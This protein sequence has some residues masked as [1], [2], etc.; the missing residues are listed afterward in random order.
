MNKFSFKLIKK[1]QSARLGQII[2]PHGKIDT[3]IFM[4]VG[5]LGSVKTASPEEVVALGGQII[6][7]NNYHLYLRPGIDIIEKAGGIHS[8][9]G[10]K[11]PLLTDSGGFQVFS[12]GKGNKNDNNLVKVHSDGVEFRSHLDGSKHLF[13]PENVVEMQERIGADIIMC[14]DECAPHDSNHAYAFDAM[15]RTHEW[16]ER[17]LVAHEKAKRQSK[18]GNYQAIFGIV[19]GVLFDDL[20]IDSTKFMAEHNFDGIAIGGLSVG[21]SKAEM[22]HIL[23]IIAPFLPESKPRYLMGVGSPEDLLEGVERGIDM[24]DCVLAT[25]IARNGSVWTREGRINLNNAVFSADFQPID[26]ECDCYTCQN[27]SRAYIAHLI[28]E[29]EIFGIRLTT[30]HNLRFLMNLM[31]EVRDS[32]SKNTFA[33]YKKE[34]LQQFIK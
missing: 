12:L 18:Q 11:G 8:F 32:I 4:P 28:R 30:L 14:L 22:A 5:T 29:K 7:A 23:E 10:W 24:F 33:R 21:E 17:C 25:R 6:L 3:P 2:T 16:G 31:K 19:Q 27:Y 1:D 13:T 15:Q 9:M 26:P 34:F 20:R